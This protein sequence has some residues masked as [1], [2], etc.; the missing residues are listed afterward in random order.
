M[1]KK[2]KES[3]DGIVVSRIVAEQLAEFG[4]NGDIYM[5]GNKKRNEDGRVV[6]SYGLSKFILNK[7]QN[8][9]YNR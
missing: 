9:N 8:L 7:N 1:L 4:Y 3:C 6:G 2:I 5:I